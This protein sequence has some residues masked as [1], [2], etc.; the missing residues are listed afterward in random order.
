MRPVSPAC[1]FLLLTLLH[2]SSSAFTQLSSNDSMVYQVSIKQALAV[3]HRSLDK[4]TGLYNGSQYIPYTNLIK[5]DHPYFKSDSMYRGDIIYDS[6]LYENV[7]M[8][9]DLVK[10][11][12]VIN[13]PFNIYKIS[14]INEKINAF[15][16]L[17]HRFYWVQPD[18]INRHVL[19]AGFYDKLY[20][21]RVNLYER[22]L[23]RLQEVINNQELSRIIIPRNDFYLEMHGRFYA[24]NKQKTLYRL[25]GN[26]KNEIQQFIRK[27]KLSYRKDKENTLTRVIAY[28]DTLPD[29]DINNQGNKKIDR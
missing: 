22:E 6:V 21:G 25:L 14:L 5:D 23:K 2:C 7:P 29:T 4:P 24:I 13:D 12:V 10:E 16:L 26:R 19:S 11:Q 17:N 27:N 1:S 18:S 28:Y 8:Y 3:Y 20:E 15:T 9:Y